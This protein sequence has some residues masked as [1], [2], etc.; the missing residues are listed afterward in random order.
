M[1]QKPVMT[2]DFLRTT[3]LEAKVPRYTSYPP[4]TRFTD[5]VGPALY[6]D[7]LAALPETKAISLYVHVP[8]CR[9][10]CWFC[11][12]RTQGTATA[13]P[14]SRFLDTLER[15][16]TRVA[17]A[18]GRA[19][20]VAALHL[21]GGTPTLLGPDQIARLELVL[22]RAFD[23]SHAPEISVE[24]DPCELDA[25]R[26]DALVEM[27]MTRASIGVQDIDPVVQDAIGRQQSAETTAEA[28]AGLRA[29]GVASVNMDLL[30]GLPHQTPAR[31]AATLDVILGHA[32]DRIALY[33]YAHVPWMAKRQRLI[34][35][36][37][38]P[39]PEARVALAEQARDRLIAAGY[40]P[41]GIDHYARPG[42]SMAR[43]ARDGTLR[44]NFQGYTTDPAETL[45]AL[46]PSAIS[47]LPQGYAQNAAATRDWATALDAG[48]LATARGFAL[49]AADQMAAA[50]IERLMC[51]GRVDLAALARTHSQDPAP[52]LQR[53]E[54]ALRE[55]PGIAHLTGGQLQ[56]SDMRYARLM[57][58]RMDPGMA[59]DP[60]RF[61]MAS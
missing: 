20:P 33:G 52:H 47:R 13:A 43:A 61:S 40:V 21:G 42:D 24:I 45:V 58:A 5:A 26:L 56:L 27:G 51:D 16:T 4:A 15:E 17:A 2:Q 50:A 8:F 22:R 18:I 53:I 34:P 46:G 57:A 55:L 7:W 30:Y 19:Q 38:L 48:T 9:R 6:R 41:V 11:A 10:L 29:R 59:E 37:A 44:R 12:C 49:S 28:V 36:D 23:L 1:M 39:G 60:S 54:A 31:L 32:P 3:L 14:L 25:A 35:E